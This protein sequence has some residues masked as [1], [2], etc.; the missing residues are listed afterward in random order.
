MPL[1]TVSLTNLTGKPSD[2][3]GL[4]FLASVN[5]SF[6]S[7]TQPSE[8]RQWTLRWT[9]L[10]LPGDGGRRCEF[11]SGRLKRGQS[12]AVVGLQPRDGDRFVKCLFGRLGFP[13][14][15]SPSLVSWA[16]TA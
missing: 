11:G 13:S 8:P 9:D 7:Q 12:L 15:I 6:R 4:P 2:P 3:E 1:K 16:N 5:S 14:L 10:Q